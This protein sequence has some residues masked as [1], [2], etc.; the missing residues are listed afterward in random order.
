MPPWIRA[1]ASKIKTNSEAVQLADSERT[2][3]PN[4]TM[5]APRG[6]ARPGV[7][8]FQV[9]IEARIHGYV[10]QPANPPQNGARQTFG[11]HDPAPPHPARFEPGWNPPPR[12]FGA[13]ADHSG[14]LSQ[15][16]ILPQNGA[17]QTSGPPIQCPGCFMGGPRACALAERKTPHSVHGR[18]RS[19]R[20]LRLP[21]NLPQSGATRTF[22]C[23]TPATS[24]D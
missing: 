16:A 20:P 21:A 15:P 3:R 6:L 10:P 7:P 23:R 9:G 4:A 2:P 12:P 17:R 24:A 13:L 18:V 19:P 5:S 8:V 22:G 11:P 14:Y 1:T